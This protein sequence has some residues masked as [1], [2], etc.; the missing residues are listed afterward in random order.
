M[1]KLFPLLCLLALAVPTWGAVAVDATMTGGN[2]A[3][4]H[5]FQANSI[6]SISTTGITV[7]GSA[8]CLLYMIGFEGVGASNVP[9]GLS[10]TWGGASMTA[11]FGT[12][13]SYLGGTN[14][15]TVQYFV[16][17]NPASGSQTIAISWTTSQS[18]YMSAISFTGTDTSTCIKTTDNASNTFSNGSLTVTSDTNGATVAMMISNDGTPTTNFT[19]IWANSALNPGG[20]G[21]YHLG[22]TSNAHTFTSGGGDSWVNAGVHVIASGSPPSNRVT[23]AAV[24]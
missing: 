3:D 11:A 19:S 24:Y 9:T 5:S 14:A 17:V 7:G 16:K 13:P 2:S 12:L 1:R 8:S 23:P 4:G 20:A 10:A 22:G 18:V 21:T 15:T 6:T